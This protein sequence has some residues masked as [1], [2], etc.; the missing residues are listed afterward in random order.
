MTIILYDSL[1]YTVNNVDLYFSQY[2]DKYEFTDNR[3][4]NIDKTCTLKISKG[5]YLSFATYR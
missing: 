2:I 1:T 3:P 4:Y 5:L